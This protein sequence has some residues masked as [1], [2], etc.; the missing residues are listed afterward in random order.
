MSNCNTADTNSNTDWFTKMH[1][2]IIVISHTQNFSSLSE[3]IKRNQ[4]LYVKVTHTG[5]DREFPESM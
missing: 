4:D 2:L 1:G 5:Y 3:P